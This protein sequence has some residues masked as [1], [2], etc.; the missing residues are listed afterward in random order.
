M[1]YH[2]VLEPRPMGRLIGESELI[3]QGLTPIVSDGH[4]G[5]KIGGAKPFVLNCSNGEWWAERLDDDQVLTLV[6]LAKAVN[7]VVAG[8]EGES[9]EVADGVLTHRT[10]PP[11]QREFHFHRFNRWIVLVLTMAFFAL[12]ATLIANN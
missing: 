8:D 10:L 1:S 11:K 6:K 7:A 2:V 5:L 12:I 3:A 9:Y 4:A